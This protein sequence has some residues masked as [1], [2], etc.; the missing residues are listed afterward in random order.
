MYYI[1]ALLFVVASS[2]SAQKPPALSGN[3]FAFDVNLG[4]GGG[5]PGISA[6]AGFNT[7]YGDN[8]LQLRYMLSTKLPSFSLPDLE[9]P[10]PANNIADFAVMY[11]NK[12]QPTERSGSGGF[13][14]GIG[15]VFGNEYTKNANEPLGY[16]EKKISTYGLALKAEYIAP[17]FRVIGFGAS[18]NANINTQ[19]SFATFTVTLH[20]GKLY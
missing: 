2:A 5:T 10:V 17:L 20:V 18:A 6:L 12:K 14:A 16:S 13:S 19:R 9:P 1:L 11:S 3:T 4:F 15:Y 7:S 8:G